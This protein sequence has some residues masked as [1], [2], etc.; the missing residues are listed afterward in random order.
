MKQR[1]SAFN[2][3]GGKNN[4]QVL[5]WIVSNLSK[6]KAFHLVDVFGGSGAVLLNFHQCEIKTYNDV[7]RDIVNFFS[8]LRDNPEGLMAALELTPFSRE[9]YEK[10]RTIKHRNRTE[11]A[12]RFFVR[13]VQSFGNSG[14]LK[15]YNS[16]SYTIRDSRYAVSQ[17]TARYLS[18]VEG[19][20]LLINEVRKWQI[21][22]SDFSKIFERYDS[23]STLFYCDPPYVH[24]SRSLHQK[25]KNELT[26][27]RHEQLCNIL[28][29]I[30]GKYLLS[31]YANDLYERELKY[32]DKV[33]LGSVKTAGADTTEVLWAN[34]PLN[35]NQLF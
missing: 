19:L 25:Y 21:E 27:K 11:W 15:T 4:Q 20:P 23:G 22:H 1:L 3:F 17:S 24:A 9:E 5:E 10:I 2:Y 30:K 31:G 35:L 33:S 7:N 28:N 32:T 12:R 18:K 8:Q 14:A 29:N 26:D 6:A 13:T 16:W 34:Y